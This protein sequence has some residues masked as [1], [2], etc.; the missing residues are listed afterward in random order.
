MKELK[1]LKAVGEV[2]HSHNRTPS[3][4]SDSNMTDS[5]TGYSVDHGGHAEELDFKCA[6]DSTIE[7]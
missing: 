4:Q 1:D 7:K 5:S 2:T 6:F 3:G